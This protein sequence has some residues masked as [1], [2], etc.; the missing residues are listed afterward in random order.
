MFSS[1]VGRDRNTG[2]RESNAGPC[3]IDPFDSRTGPRL[4]IAVLCDGVGTRERGQRAAQ[5]AENVKLAA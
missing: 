3:G 5:L 4:I 2:G 1:H